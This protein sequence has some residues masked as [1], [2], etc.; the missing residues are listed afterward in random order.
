MSNP[1]ILYISGSL[2]LG[3]VTR[4]IA[5]SREIRKLI[6]GAKIEWLAADPATMMLIE[7]GEILVPG[8]DQYANENISAEQSA[9]GYSLNLLRYLIKSRNVWNKNIDFFMN[10][11]S[12]RSYDL[13]IG[14][15]TYEI[16]LALRNHS[17]VKKF[18]FAMIF[19]FVGLE[20]MTKNLLEKL[21]VYY[22]NRVWSHDYRKKIKPPYDLALFV[23][24]IQDVPDI[25]FGFMLPNRRDLARAMYTFIGYIFPFNVTAYNNKY[26]VRKKLGYG[27]EPLV[28]ASIG[29][30]AIG[31]ELLN[32]CG[33]AYISAKEGIPG[34][35]LI[36]V[37]GP[38][39]AANS[40]KLPEGV[41]VKGFIP[42]LYEHF[43][44]CDLAIVQ[45][46]ATSTLELT[47]LRRPFLY[48]PI[49][50][51]CGQANVARMLKQHGAGIRMNLKDTT[52][53]SLARTIIDSIGKEVTYPDIPSDGAQKAAQHIVNLLGKFENSQ[54]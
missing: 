10:L 6:P 15:E 54:P 23:G 1:N 44:A 34:L 39:I 24:E 22:W 28:I 25:T 30:T 41:V 40:L 37:T 26:E 51:H 4:D 11:I 29:G 31:K 27:T 7:E 47:A 35:Q 8:S 16:N 20:S 52:P 13:V 14:D 38:R 50:G 33:E 17:E 53:E 19:D 12:S 49:E 5:I 21:G 18:P 9:K 2:G 48:F 45:G 43:A 36:L 3:H 32:L 46:G 42:R